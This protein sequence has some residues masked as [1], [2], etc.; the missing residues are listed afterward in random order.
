MLQNILKCDQ[1]KREKSILET[2]VVGSKTHEVMRS[3]HEICPTGASKILGS[4]IESLEENYKRSV[5][6]GWRHGKVSCSQVRVYVGG[7]WKIGKGSLEEMTFE[8]SS[9]NKPF[10]AGLVIM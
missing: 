1:V 3:S 10:Q 7:G 5:M 8:H 2:W 6:K 4:L 9:Y